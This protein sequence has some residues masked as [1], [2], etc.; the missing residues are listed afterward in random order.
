MTTPPWYREKVMV[1]YYYY[2]YDDTT[3]RNSDQ[4]KSGHLIY[5]ALKKLNMT[6]SSRPP[7]RNNILFVYSMQSLTSWWK[8]SA[9]DPYTGTIFSLVTPCS[10][11]RHDENILQP[12]PTPPIKYYSSVSGGL[13]ETKAAIW[14]QGSICY[15]GYGSVKS[16]VLFLHFSHI[17]HLDICVQALSRITNKKSRLFYSS[18]CFHG[19]R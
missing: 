12:T 8:H 4:D 15:R 16:T 7:Q 9:A 19:R 2:I 10:V 17:M 3:T 5:L 13:R 6:S 11:W 14:V 18:K 1:Y